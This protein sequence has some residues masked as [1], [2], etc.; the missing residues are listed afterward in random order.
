[1]LA[2]GF[3]AWL[4]T[5]VVFTPAVGA[6]IVMLIPRAEESAIKTVALLTTALTFAWSVV[7][8]GRF[9]YS[10]ASRLQFQVDKSWIEVIN[11][12]YHLGLDGISLPLLVLSAFITL[13]CIIYSW[14][15]FPEP[16]N[17]KAFL[18]LILILEVGMNGTFVAQDLILFFIFFEIVLLP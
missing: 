9:D 11:S 5:L 12:R 6:L 17:P 4:L 8:L 15:H 13:L 16:Y 14:N 3:D 7:I 1:M 18:A 10:E 2:H